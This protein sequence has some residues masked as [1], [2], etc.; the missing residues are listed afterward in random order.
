MS[1]SGRTNQ[2]LHFVRLALAE[3][4]QEGEKGN[5]QQQRRHEESALFHLHAG[6][7]SFCAEVVA[8][9]QMPPFSVLRELFDRRGLPTEVKELNLL[10]Q[11]SSSWLYAMMRTHQRALVQGLEDNQINTG[12]IT[13]QSDYL[14]LIHNWLIE[15]EN[16]VNRHR[17]HYLEC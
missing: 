6:F 15:L 16:L 13:S 2:C 7:M 17:E 3:G 8:Q 11:D 1:T 14:A 12:L 10:S 5:Q 4:E 9:Y